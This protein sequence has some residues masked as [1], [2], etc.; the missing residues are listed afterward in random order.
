MAH[1]DP[2]KAYKAKR[3]FRNTSEPQDGGAANQSGQTFVIQKH[4]ASHLHYDF[5]LELN[6]SMKSWAVPKGPSYDPKDKRMAVQV[7]D[8]PIAYN[9]FEGVIPA[10]QYG[11]GKVII[12]DKGTWQPLVDPEQGYRDGNLKFALQ[13][14]KL[15]GNWALIRIKGKGEKNKMKKQPPWLLIKEKD[16]F[17]R[18]AIEYSVVDELPDSVAQLGPPPGIPKKTKDGA[19]KES[20]QVQSKAA[21]AKS[22]VKPDAVPAGA[23]KAALPKLIA[24]QLATLVDVPPSDSQA[25]LYEIKYDGYRLLARIQGQ[26]IALLTRNGNDWTHKLPVLVEALHDAKLPSGWYDG[27]I[28]MSGENGLPDFQALQGAFDSNRTQQIVYVFI[29]LAVF[30][31]DSTCGPCRLSSAE[32]SCSPCWT[33]PYRRRYV[34]ARCSKQALAISW[35][36]PVVLVWKA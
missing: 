30:T 29:R 10:K 25:W 27:E 35:R 7:E 5:R 17:A 11:A 16:S 24:P 36:R 6:G 20:K 32:S 4:W 22:T 15:R 26:K 3:N 28:V 23:A 31:Q 21:Q 34:S 19:M 12:W 13:G 1:P 14:H 2:L 33:R 9:E 8:H 18:P